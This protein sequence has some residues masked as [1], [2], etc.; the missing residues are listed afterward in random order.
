MAPAS[1][2]SLSSRFVHIYGKLKHEAW[3][4]R[5][6]RIGWHNTGFLTFNEGMHR[7]INIL[8]I[9]VEDRA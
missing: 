7:F 1:P 3:L 2:A 6:R 9:H 4:D 8:A 5:Y